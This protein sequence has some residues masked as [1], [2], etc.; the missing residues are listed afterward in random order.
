MAKKPYKELEFNVMSLHEA[1][2]LTKIAQK[3]EEIQEV[4]D[5]IGVAVKQQASKG[6][7][8]TEI[9]FPVYNTTKGK[10]DIR[11]IDEA[12]EAYG[13]K[14]FVVNVDKSSLYDKFGTNL[15]F[16]TNLGAKIAP[17]LLETNNVIVNVC[18]GGKC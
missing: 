13:Q 2:N 1:Q 6:Y 5:R 9:R 16:I 12:A 17:N 7:T 10:E 15:T 8:F 14:G 11:L 18:W 4:I 3:K